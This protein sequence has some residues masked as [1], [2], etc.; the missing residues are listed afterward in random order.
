MKTIKISKDLLPLIFV[1]ASKQRM[2]ISDYIDNLLRIHLV[3][4]GTRIIY[5][6]ENCDTEVE[7]VINHNTGKCI[8]CKS[9]VMIYS[10]Q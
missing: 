5:K 1:N 3:K 10:N 7:K 6:C 4:Q 8:N 2:E 9:S